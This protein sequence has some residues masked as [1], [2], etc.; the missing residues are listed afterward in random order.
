M[1]T[2]GTIREIQEYEADI[3]IHY[4]LDAYETYSLE[5]FPNECSYPSVVQTTLPKLHN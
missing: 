5:N 2:M 1:R 3:G 4:G